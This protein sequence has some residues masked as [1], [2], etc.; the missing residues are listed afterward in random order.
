M[1][2]N[3]F[4]TGLA[5]GITLVGG[6]GIIA[7]GVRFLIAP[8]AG[9]TGFGIP[10][11]TGDALAYLDVKGIRDIVSGLVVLIPLALGLRR[12]LGWTL[13]AAALTPATDAA[14]VLTHGGSP[15]VAFGIHAATAAA[16]LLAAG[17]L[18]RETRP[19]AAA[20]APAPTR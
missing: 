13:L 11:P 17:L 20:A 6:L 14:I 7:V 3:R 19:S 12:P 5:T 18:F 2:T 9:A 10:A 16:L 15:A 1:R 8:E 4:A